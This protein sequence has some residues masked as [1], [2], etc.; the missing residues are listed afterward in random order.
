MEDMKQCPNC[1]ESIKAQAIICRYCQSNLAFIAKEQKGRFIK[2]CLKARDKTYFG[3]IFI[4]SHISRL[5]N[6]INDARQFIALTNTREETET[7][8]IQIGFLAINKNAVEWVRLMEKE[9]VSQQDGQF[10]RSLD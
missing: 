1:A 7:T 9:S 10:S 5:S 6:V 4:P 2:V 8:E 3:D